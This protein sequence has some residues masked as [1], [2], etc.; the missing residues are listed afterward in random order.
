MR[1]DAQNF[2]GVRVNGLTVLEYVGS[3][4]HDTIW[5]CRCDCGMV[6][7]MRGLRLRHGSVVSCGCR[8]MPAP[9]NKS[10][11]ESPGSNNYS[12]EYRVWHGIKTRT[13]NPNRKDSKNY[14]GRGIG[15]CA[16]WRGSFPAFLEH[17]GRRPSAQH[18]LGRIDNDGGY[19]PGNVRWET[20][21][22][23]ANNTRSNRIVT[24]AD[25]SMT[26]AQWSRF[27]GV[28]PHL[29]YG[30]VERGKAID[31][32]ILGANPDQFAEH[33]QINLAEL[34]KKLREEYERRAKI[35]TA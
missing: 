18:S 1:R 27:L 32:V 14:L 19:E 16:E 11:G 35:L 5:S 31:E 33:H 20:L 2:T 8:P 9:P 25:K 22:Q 34:Q 29:L 7:N 26:V 30:R 21:I 3:A 17:V 24:V 23:Q 6:V 4:S 15:M 10:H 13:S 12:A 28:K